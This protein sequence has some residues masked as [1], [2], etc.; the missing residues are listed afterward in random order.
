MYL[1][2]VLLEL[3]AMLDSRGRVTPV[4]R[5]KVDIFRDVLCGT[6]LRANREN[7]LIPTSK[8]LN[9]DLVTFH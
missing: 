3:F 6:S 7:L 9:I 8:Y 5:T 2:A 1:V 4:C